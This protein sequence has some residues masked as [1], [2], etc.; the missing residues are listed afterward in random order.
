MRFADGMASIN[1]A[2][3][4]G[5]LVSGILAIK[6]GMRAVTRVGIKIG[7][8]VTRV[9]IKVGMNPVGIKI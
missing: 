6:I 1:L 7:T 3:K 5:I 2:I 4:V 9:G 8:L